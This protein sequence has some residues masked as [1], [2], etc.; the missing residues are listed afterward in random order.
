MIKRT[1][2]SKG[3]D[4]NSELTL[5]HAMDLDKIID[6]N[7]LNGYKFFRVTSNLMLWKSEY[8]W[9]DLKDL[10]QIQMYLHSVGVKVDTHGVRLLH[11]MSFQCINFTT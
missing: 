3:V 1:F 5:K 9:E 6:W 8:E 2:D 10:K 7:I 4:Y 11:L